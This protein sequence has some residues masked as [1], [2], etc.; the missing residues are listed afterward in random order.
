M[1]LD[2][3]FEG[4]N[5]MLRSVKKELFLASVLVRHL[6]RSETRSSFPFVDYVI[7]VGW[8]YSG[9][10]ISSVLEFRIKI[11]LEFVLF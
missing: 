3:D 4:R 2:I 6:R 1:K 7:S 10:V 9:E 11:R 8:T 5:D